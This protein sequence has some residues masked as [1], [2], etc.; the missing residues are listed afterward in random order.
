MYVEVSPRQSGKTTRLVDAVVSY[1]QQN[2]SDDLKI[3]LCCI[4]INSFKHIKRLIRGKI[5]TELTNSLPMDYSYESVLKLVDSLYLTKIICVTSRI[6]FNFDPNTIS[7][8]FFDEFSFLEPN[9]I[10]HPI[11]GSVLENAY[12]CTT[13]SSENRTTNIIVNY[14]IENDYQIH[15][16]NPWTETLIEE[17]MSFNN[18]FREAVLNDWV[19]YME[20]K[21]LLKGIKENLIRKFI[22]K[23]RFTLW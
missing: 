12:Y 21:G 15:Y 22:K 1:L 11:N 10:L 5:S 4:N 9:K 2:F 13:P 19:N 23:H 18:Y 3:V 14:C 7:Y 8:W 16:N 17:Q 6:N 20:E